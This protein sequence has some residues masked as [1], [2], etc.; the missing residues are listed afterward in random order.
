MTVGG[1]MEYLSSIESR[2]Y[3]PFLNGSL[4]LASRLLISSEFAYGARSKTIINYRLPSNLQFELN[5]I[6]YAKDQ[7]A[8][9]YNY[10]EERKAVISLPVHTRGFNAFTRLSFSQI[11]IPKIKCMSSELLFSGVVAGVNTN[12]TT[13]ALLNDPAHPYV[14]S[15]LSLTFRLPAKITL[16]PQAQYQY[17]VKKISL[18][19]CELQKR[20]FVHGFL[21]L[22]YEKDFTNKLSNVGIG[23]RYDFSFAQTA[24][25]ASRSNR[26]TAFVQSARGSLLYDRKTSYL[27][28]GNRPAVGKGGLIIIPYLD[29]NGNGKRDNNEPKAYGLG[30]QINGGRLKR[31]NHDTTI[32]ITELEP[33]INYHIQ[34][35]RNGF[36]HIAWQLKNKSISI[37]IDPNQFKL[38]EIPVAVAGE[39]TGMVYMNEKSDKNG[40]ARIFVCFYNSDSLLVGR[41]LTESDGYFSFVGLAPGRY[42]ARVDAGQ[43][44]NL[45]MSSSPLF[46]PFTIASNKDGDV[47]EGIEFV[48]QPDAGI[49]TGVAESTR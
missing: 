27:E 9:R 6:K 30:L 29:V 17:Q 23:L 12:L 36:D 34:L 26:K 46:V 38:I 44:R 43:L 13:Y 39:A 31:N 20:F 18:L 16:T 32:C 14:H 1:G 10:Q 5:Y 25:S 28:A 24:F 45:H 19:K 33:Y 41:T 47:A 42:T 48:L 7:K 2:K 15:N 35:D 49:D 37:T 21:N 4:R 8:I 40:L 22:S 3:M 11:I